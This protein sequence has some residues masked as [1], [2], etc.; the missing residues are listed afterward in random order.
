MCSHEMLRGMVRPR[1][2]SPN[3]RHSRSMPVS[4]HDVA[5]EL[6]RRLGEV[7]TAKLHKLL[8][9]VQ[10]WHLAFIGRPAFKEAI[11]AWVNGPVV[12]DLWADEKHERGRPPEQGLDGEVLQAVD[13]VVGRYGG[14]SGRELIRMTHD[15]DPWRDLSESDDPAVSPNP[16]ITHEALTRWFRN[17]EHYLRHQRDVERLKARADIYSFGQLE[18]TPELDDAIARALSGEAIRD[19][20]PRRR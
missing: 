2:P 16:E 11:R 5:D 19:R 12:A 1:S 18:R 20:R 13:Y 8:Y 15:E 7:G 6:R 4:A 9:Y 17:D 14:L 3:L 10:G